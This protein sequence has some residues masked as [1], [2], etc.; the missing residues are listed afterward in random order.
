MNKAF[1]ALLESINSQLKILNDN[2]FK[3]FDME[4]PEYFI[5]S[6]KYDKESDEIMFFTAENTKKPFAEGTK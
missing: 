2:G 6:I 1:T 3:I 5:S 4:N